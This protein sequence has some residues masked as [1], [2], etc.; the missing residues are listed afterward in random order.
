MT[1]GFRRPHWTDLNS[2]D[3]NF[4]CILEDKLCSDNVGSEDDLKGN[5]QV[6][7]S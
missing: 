4:C 7:T 5:I 3:L 1:T 6:T 2:C